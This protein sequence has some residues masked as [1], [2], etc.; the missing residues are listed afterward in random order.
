MPS[1]T[2]L[3]Y[4]I[5]TSGLNKCFDQVV[6]FAS[7]RTDLNLNELE[8]HN[9]YVKLNPDVV[10]SPQAFLTHKISL[11]KLEQQGM[12]EYE[13]MLIIHKLFNTE[14]TITI[15][16]NTLGFDDE[17]LRWSFFRNFLDP[18]SHQ[19]A[20]G[21]ERCDVYPIAI[22]FYL[23]KN[24]ILHWYNKN[25][26]ISLKLENLSDANN[27][28]P[29][30]TSQAHCA[31]HDVETTINLA[32]ILFKEHAS[33]DYCSKLLNKRSDAEMYEKRLSTVRFSDLDFPYAILIDGSFGKKNNFQTVALS[34][35][36]HR[37]YKN[38]MIFLDLIKNDF[39]QIASHDVIRKIAEKTWVYRKK[40]GEP[41]LM[42]PTHEKFTKYMPNNSE[43]YDKVK[44]NIEY[45]QNNESILHAIIDYHLDYKYPEVKNLDLDASLYNKNI[46]DNSFKFIQQ[47]FHK[48]ETIDEKLNLSDKISDKD[49]RKQCRRIL[50]RNY[51]SQLSAEFQYE[52]LTWLKQREKSDRRDYKNQQRLT[53]HEAFNEVKQL[54]DEF[55][56]DRNNKSDYVNTMSNI[57][58]LA[59]LTELE[60]F[61]TQKKAF[62]EK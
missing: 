4:D 22:M 2:Y 32:K 53:F 52:F 59:I 39:T 34:L 49:M 7:I 3:F 30:V 36:R 8:R 60:K 16:Y 18:Y 38:Q 17:F 57:E 40:F 37:H 31:L 33:W 15:G 1:Q 46:F 13:A 19:Y 23:F 56:D 25:N 61:F 28:M 58:Q 27:L 54:Q 6:Q 55:A 50:G 14:G 29:N 48:S 11:Q 20:N 24:E 10:P 42:L 44:M 12:C 26:E 5:E 9:F 47:S 41:P 43:A 51:L 21:C 62:L 45:L 35:G